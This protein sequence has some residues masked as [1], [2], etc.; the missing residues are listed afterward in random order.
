MVRKNDFGQPIGQP[1]PPDW[2]PPA[3]PPRTNLVGAHV[4]VEPLDPDQHA[5]ELFA[6]NCLDPNGEGWTYLAYGPFKD[7]S[8]YK[9]WMSTQCM[10]ADPMFWAYIDVGTER[11]VGLGSYMRIDP[12]NAVIEV[13]HLRFSPKL[14]R[15]TMATEAMYLK[16]RNVF[17][18]GYRRYEWKCDSLNAPSRRAA[19]RYGFNFEGIFRQA[20]HY[21]GRN[22]DTAW[23][24][25]TD[26]DWPQ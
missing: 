13:G 4:R 12:S 24:A 19:E 9:E 7:I 3:P 5:E 15:T 1:L 18:L 25:I 21:K 22:R 10:G 11:A 20:T 17:D 2:M 16:M 8:S 6:A 23:F 14:Q 26:S